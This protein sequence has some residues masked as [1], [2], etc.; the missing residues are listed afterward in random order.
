MNLGRYEPLLRAHFERLL[1]L[2][3]FFEGLL[4]LTMSILDHVGSHALPCI[5]DSLGFERISV[6]RAG[7]G[8][9]GWKRVEVGGSAGELGAGESVRVGADERA[10][11]LEGENSVVTFPSALDSLIVV[12]RCGGRISL[13]FARRT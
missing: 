5:V 3:P 9:N 2:L 13:S 4:V 8:E 1:L 7:S 10:T 6:R 11:G 12:L